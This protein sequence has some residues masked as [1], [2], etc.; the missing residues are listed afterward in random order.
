M[1]LPNICEN[2]ATGRIIL[3]IGCTFVLASCDAETWKMIADT[4]N[5]SLSDDPYFNPAPA[6]SYPAY[7][8]NSSSPISD[9]NHR[10]SRTACTK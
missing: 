5:E 8:P 3:A 7:A 2:R 10:C 6:P 4:G 9:P 1:K